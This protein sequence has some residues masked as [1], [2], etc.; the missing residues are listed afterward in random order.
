MDI[1]SGSFTEPLGGI[2]STTYISQK[3]LDEQTVVDVIDVKGKK[4][5]ESARVYVDNNSVIRR[6]L[7]KSKGKGAVMEFFNP[8]FDEPIP[9]KVFA[10]TK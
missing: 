4:S 10:L 1:L 5:G 9:E 7:S 8:T 3:M 2:E 6:I